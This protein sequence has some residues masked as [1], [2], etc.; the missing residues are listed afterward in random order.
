MKPSSLRSVVAHNLF[1]AARSNSGGGGG[2]FGFLGREGRDEGA[3]VPDCDCVDS[4]EA[5]ESFIPA[6]AF[7]RARLPIPGLSDSDFRDCSRLMS[8]RTSFF[9]FEGGR[10]S[11]RSTG[12]PRLTRK[13]RRIRDWVQLGGWRGG[14]VISCFQ[15]ERE[16]SEGKIGEESGMGSWEGR[17]EIV[18]AV[19]WGNMAS[20]WA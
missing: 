19:E 3:F 4:R 5:V 13:R 10:I 20:R 12:T 15:R 6:W 14:G 17:F 11:S 1:T 9:C 2:P 16:R 7:R 8:G 18:S